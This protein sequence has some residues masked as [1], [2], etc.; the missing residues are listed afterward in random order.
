MTRYFLPNGLLARGFVLLL[1]IA[2]VSCSDYSQ[3]SVDVNAAPSSVDFVTTTIIQDVT[4][5]P[6]HFDHDP[7]Y[8]AGHTTTISVD[9]GAYIDRLNELRADVLKEFDENPNPYAPSD[10]ATKQ[11]AI[12]EEATK[13]PAGGTIRVSFYDEDTEKLDVSNFEF[14]LFADGQRVIDAETFAVSGEPEKYNKTLFTNSVELNLPRDISDAGLISLEIYDS[15]S[16]TTTI[17]AMTNKVQN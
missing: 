1:S 3:K 5:I 14:S 15:V 17:F 4:R 6:G 11:A 8:P 16:Q 13:I 2:V 12:D 7:K 9:Y 10:A